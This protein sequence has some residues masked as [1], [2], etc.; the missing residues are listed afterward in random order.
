MKLREVL[1]QIVVDIAEIK[2]DLNYHIKRT[3]RLEEQVQPVKQHVDTM[4]SLAKITLALIAAG[5][6]IAAIV[7]IF[8]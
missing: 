8:F 5:S 7:K 1:Q 3:D 6:G 4:N 2:K